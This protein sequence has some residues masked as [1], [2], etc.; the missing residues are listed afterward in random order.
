MSCVLLPA[1][2]LERDTHIECDGR[3]FDIGEG[4]G[5]AGLRLPNLT[6]RR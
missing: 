3:G 5:E 1:M 4:R 6:V 2:S